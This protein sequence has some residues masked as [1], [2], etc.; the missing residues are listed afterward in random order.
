M[1]VAAL[2]IAGIGRAQAADV[3]GLIVSDLRTTLSAQISGTID[4]ITVDMGDTFKSGQVLVRVKDDIY[5]TQ[6]ARLEAELRSTRQQLDAN[7]K[8]KELNSIGTLDVLQSEALV[9]QKESERHLYEIQWRQCTLKAPF[10]GRVVERLA[11]PHQFVTPGTPLL[12]IIDDKHLSVQ[13]FVPSHW[14]RSLRPGQRCMLYVD[15]IGMT[16][17][18][19]V[20]SLGAR[21]DANSQ[22]LEVRAAIEDRSPQ[23]LAGM[24]GQ[25]DFGD[26]IPGDAVHE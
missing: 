13:A 22:M 4:A 16:F 23:L 18:A 26:L 14:I 3:R 2:Q 15:E 17:S 10:P 8:L 5:R 7:R 21:I 25:L 24:S 12:D 9:K 19:R 11:S 1:V 6:L 20:T